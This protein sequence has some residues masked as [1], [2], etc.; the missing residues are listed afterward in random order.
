MHRPVQLKKII[1]FILFFVVFVLSITMTAR[2]AGTIQLENMQKQENPS[3]TRITL[4]FSSLPEYKVNRSGQRLDLLLDSVQISSEL[5]KLPEDESVVKILLA[6]KPQ[7][8]LVSLLLRRPPK[9]VMTESLNDP[10]RVVM[11]IYWEADEGTRPGVAFRIADM[12]AKKA[13]RR[14]AHFQRQSPW[15]GHW[16]EFFRD[17]RSYWT[18]QLPD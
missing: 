10:S 9:Q 2:A 17:Y 1:G 15:E 11:D 4:T 13:G 3:F 14:A 18:L 16:N 8:L 5:H 12:P 6:E 7:Q